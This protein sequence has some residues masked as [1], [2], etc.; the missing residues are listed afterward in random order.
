MESA[1]SVSSGAPAWPP[2]SGPP[3]RV[4]GASSRGAL[5]V[6]DTLGQ[7]RRECF[8][9]PGFHSRRSPGAEVP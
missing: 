3:G 8:Q 4:M 2:T 7:R 9:G 5:G 6:T 1:L